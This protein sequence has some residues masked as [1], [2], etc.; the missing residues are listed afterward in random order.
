MFDAKKVKDECVEWIRDFFEKN[1]KDSNAVV[2]IS[3]GKDS[4]VVAALCV[5]ALG[6][7]RVIGVLMP[8]G[9]QSD[10]E[11]AREVCEVL[12]INYMEVNINDAFRDLQYKVHYGANYQWC[13]GGFTPSEQSSINLAPRLR[14]TTLYYISQNF[15]GRV[16]NT[17]N[18]SEDYVGYSTRWGDAVGD[19]APLGGLLTDEVVAIGDALGLPHDL[20]H[21]TP[22]DGLCGKTDE[23]NLGFTYDQLN[24][25]IRTGSSGDEKIDEVIKDKHDKN[26]FKLQ[27]I[28]VFH[29]IS[30]DMAIKSEP[31]E[32]QYD[33]HQFL[34]KYCLTCGSLQCSG[35][36]SYA[37]E[38][39]KRRG[40]LKN[41]EEY[42]NKSIRK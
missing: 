15:N 17:C 13:I 36:L 40:H 35:P 2:G 12:D 19:F 24:T 16:A 11:D 27:P 21:K 14:M 22:S 31:L 29:R 1:G 41:Q 26:L 6:K 30:L 34:D 39:C 23:D 3:G 28:P 37:F 25:Y 38:G 33:Y 10:I 8:N 5:E 20:V 4:S 42:I 32:P 9:E 7:D 18:L